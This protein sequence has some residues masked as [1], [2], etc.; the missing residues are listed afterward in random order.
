MPRRSSFELNPT[1]EKL[2]EG[3]KGASAV[4]AGSKIGS[5][6]YL[7]ANAVLK[8]LDDLAGA[9]TG[10]DEALWTELHAT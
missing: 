6:Q 10:D 9:L 3:R 1:L 2:R 5:D 8:A 4:C 7:A